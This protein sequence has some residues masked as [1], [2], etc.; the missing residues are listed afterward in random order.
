MFTSRTFVLTEP[1]LEPVT[2][3]EVKASQRIDD[4]RFDAIIPGLIS[5]ARAI[6][7]HEAKRHF[8]QQVV[9]TELW[10]WPQY[11]Q[12]LPVYS[13]TAA[14][15]TY[16]NGASWVALAGGG[17][18]YFGLGSGTGLTAALNATWPLLPDIAG[19]PRVRIDLTVGETDA[20]AVKP[21]LKTYI[22][23]LVGQ[24]L[25]SPDLSAAAVAD[26]HPLL[27]RLLD[28]VRIWA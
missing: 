27:A 3:A 13:P 8:M 7:E 23:A 19:G 26:A 22:N 6:A 21:C 5:A 20:A 11:D 1:S 4:T 15:V 16:W 17:Y 9:R 12:A 25:Q 28:P 14:A 18:V 24:M 10:D 2:L